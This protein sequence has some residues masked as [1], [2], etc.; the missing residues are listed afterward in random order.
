MTGISGKSRYAVMF[1]GR[2]IFGLGGGSITI[3]QNAITA[4]WFKNKELAMAFGITL[5]MSRLGS[6]INYDLTTLVYN[7]FDKH[8]NYGLGW[9]FLFG[10]FLIALSLVAAMVFVSL[11]VR[12]E[13]ERGAGSKF[14]GRK[15]RF[16]DVSK[17]GVCYWCAALT[18]MAVYNIVF[19]F[20][21]IVK[22]YF[23]SGIWPSLAH[24]KEA[25]SV[26]ASILYTIGMVV[27]PFLG[28]GID[29]LGRRGWLALFGTAI[30]VPAFLSFALAK[31]HVDPAFPMTLL[32]IAYS[33]C[34]AALWPSIPLLVNMDSIGTANG[35]ATSLQMIGI[36]ICT[37]I[38]G[39]LKDSAGYTGVIWFLVGW[40]V[41]ATLFAALLIFFDR[42]DM[43]LYMSKKERE[44]ARR[45]AEVVIDDPEVQPLL[46]GIEAEESHTT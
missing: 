38:V 11:D 15:I 20:Q 23:A 24:N 41:A 28:I 12:A 22:G 25:A 32:G 5:T 4:H 19:P 37:I 6:V 30:T 9:T 44:Q 27:S 3:V 7:G 45:K 29:I 46:D 33:V 39:Q 31:G 43:K 2:F 18:I 1:I 16:R 17:F 8:T 13:K 42:K 21:A 36:G 26:R 40:C 35:V 14:I 34:A 10:S